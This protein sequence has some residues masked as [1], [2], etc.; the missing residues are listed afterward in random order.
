MRL[1]VKN[2]TPNVSLCYTPAMSSLTITPELASKPLDD[3]TF[4]IRLRIT[5]DRKHRRV[6]L[7]FAVAKRFWN[8]K[9]K[10]VRDN[11]PNAETINAAIS[12][13]KSELDGEVSMKTILKQPVTARQVQAQLRHEPVGGSYLKWARRYILENYNNGATRDEYNTIL[14][15]LQGFLG[16]NGD[17]A[18]SE[19]DYAFLK[20]YEG[21]LKTAIPGK[22]KRNGR[23]TIV[24]NLSILRIFWNEAVKAD[25]YDPPKDPFL[26]MDLTGAKV[27][28]RTRLSQ[29]QI[30]EF[31]RLDYPITSMQWR[32][33]AF[34]LMEYYLLG[35]GFRT[36]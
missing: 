26:K 36:C 25:V 17:L 7:D 16:G 30:E 9:T 24:K 20:K 12:L 11:H 32:V 3:G 1:N 28:P 23:N 14:N 22:K 15:K 5:Q 31:K 6:A 34:W 2:V 21:Y 8:E 13:K 33:R 10:R 18:F 4:R 27:K 29:E 19:L 35:C